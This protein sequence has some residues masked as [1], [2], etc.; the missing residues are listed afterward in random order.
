MLHPES[1]LDG[2]LGV[3]EAFADVEKKEVSHLVA[4]EKKNVFHS[5]RRR[6]F[7]KSKEREQKRK[8][9]SLFLPAL[10]LFSFRNG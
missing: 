6:S 7:H 8:N 1:S 9:L 3:F 10:F 4:V 5:F 2:I